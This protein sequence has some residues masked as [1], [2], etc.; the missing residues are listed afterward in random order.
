MNV[1]DKILKW[2]SY[3]LF[4]SNLYAVTSSIAICYPIDNHRSGYLGIARCF[5]VHRQ[6]PVSKETVISQQRKNF[7]QN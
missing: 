1:N 7:G 4:M 2:L 5:N 3:E 6:L